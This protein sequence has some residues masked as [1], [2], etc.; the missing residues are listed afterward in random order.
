MIIRALKCTLF[1][2]Q[3]WINLKK[4]RIDLKQKERK[5][6]LGSCWEFQT[7]FETH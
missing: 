5:E 2:P 1:F 7:N 6:V 4:F 3:S